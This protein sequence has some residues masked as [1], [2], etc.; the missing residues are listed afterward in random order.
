MHA[1][2]GLNLLLGDL[3]M[4]TSKTLKPKNTLKSREVFELDAPAASNVLLA[5]DF[6]GWQTEP[7]QL[8]KDRKGRW[9]ATISLPPGKYEYRFMADGAWVDDP[10]A[11]ARVSNPYGSHNCVR[12]VAVN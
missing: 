7:I 12:E 4:E 10:V 6:T 1:S 3:N 5:G 11:E 9:K 2:V 8:K